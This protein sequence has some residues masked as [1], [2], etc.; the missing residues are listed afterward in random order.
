VAEAGI[1]LT[2]QGIEDSLAEFASRADLSTEEFTQA[3][4]NPA[5]RAK[6][7]AISL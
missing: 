7:F 3:L 5:S 2:P 1:E 6:R 4:V